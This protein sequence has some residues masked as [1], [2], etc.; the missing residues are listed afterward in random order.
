MILSSYS[1]FEGYYENYKDRLYSFFY[2]RLSDSDLAE[3]LTSETFIK[4]FE[5]FDDYNPAYSFGTWLYTIGRN[6]LTDHFRT[7]KEV[8]SID[9]FEEE[10]GEIED[11]N[12]EDIEKTLND[13]VTVERFKEIMDT[14]PALQKECILLRY[15]DDLEFAEI[16]EITGASY[17]QVRQSVSRGMK[18]LRHYGDIFL[19]LILLF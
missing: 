8:S 16:S 18:K 6:K 15:L 9:V 14:L 3:D 19:V 4:A 13:A 2:Y 12:L 10:G 7:A 5:K 11:E 17:D 1:D